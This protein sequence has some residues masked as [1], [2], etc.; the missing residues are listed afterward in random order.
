LYFSQWGQD[1]LHQSRLAQGPPSL[2]Y[3]RYHVILGGKAAWASH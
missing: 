2:L 1:F 3:N